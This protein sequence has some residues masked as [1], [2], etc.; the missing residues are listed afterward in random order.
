MKRS[1]A[2]S[3][4]PL[5]EWVAPLALLATLVLVAGCVTKGTHLE[6]VQER[7]RLQKESAARAARITL[8]EA[9]NEALSEER[10]TLVDEIEDFRQARQELELK[11][12]TLE[13][14]RD[15][16]EADLRARETEVARRSQEVEQLRDTYGGLVA[17]LESEVTAGRIQIER[18]RQG[19]RLNLSQEILFASGSAE[20]NQ[21]GRGVIAKVAERLATVPQRIEVQGHTDD[22]AIRGALAERYPSNWEL[23]GARAASVVRLLTERGVPTDRMTAVSFGEHHPVAPNDTPEGRARNRRIEIRLLPPDDSAEGMPGQPEQST[24][25]APG[26][27]EESAGA[28]PEPPA[29]E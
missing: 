21:Q 6:V 1:V 10:V 9:S 4:A 3:S 14:V 12:E 26:Q 18:L 11:I 29:A 20:L 15:D 27:P 22:V 17:D 25:A 8:L 5:S 16:L 19:L 13:Q 28:A 23:A 2:R 24:E 7:D